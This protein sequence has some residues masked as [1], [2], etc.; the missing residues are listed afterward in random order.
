MD[1][2]EEPRGSRYREIASLMEILH[3]SEKLA[4]LAT[5]IT[6]SIEGSLRQ[7]NTTEK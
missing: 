3:G 2:V 7:A 5:D 4:Q 6:S 1:S